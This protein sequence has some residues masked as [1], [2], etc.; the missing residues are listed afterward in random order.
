M[1]WLLPLLLTSTSFASSSP[2]A[3]I[4]E[5]YDS[6]TKTESSLI[7]LKNGKKFKNL[8]YALHYI[9]EMKYK[10]HSALLFRGVVC[11]QCAV[12]LSLFV[13]PL[14]SEARKTQFTYPGKITTIQKDGAGF[15]TSGMHIRS[16]YGDC[17]K[18][19]KASLLNIK[20]V[21]NIIG[22]TIDLWNLNDKGDLEFVS[23]QKEIIL[24]EVFS[25]VKLK[26]C[27][28]INVSDRDIHED[29]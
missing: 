3:K 17:L 4:Q 5:S 20:E 18:N 10:N 22:K 27:T 29:Q 6:K 15:K 9:G 26:K 28:E 24:N 23:L 8:G 14:Y 25:A 1:K 16:F 13:Q 19:G 7:T 11:A 12:D 21:P 2:V